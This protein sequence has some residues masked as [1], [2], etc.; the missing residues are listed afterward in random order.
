MLRGIHRN[1]GTSCGVISGKKGMLVDY[2][3]YLGGSP[4]L[5]EGACIDI[6]IFE[7]SR[8]R[9]GYAI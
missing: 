8:H 1:Q 3:L 4:A 7:L 2:S 6:L 5:P 9:Q